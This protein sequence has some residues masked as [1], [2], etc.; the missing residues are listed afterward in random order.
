MD[1]TPLSPDRRAGLYVHV[2]FCT[3]ICPYCDFSVVGSRH[4]GRSDYVDVLLREAEGV[5]HGVPDESAGSRWNEEFGTVYFGGGTPSA[6]GR[7]EL[8]KLVRGLEQRVPIA[9]DAV[10]TLEA[11]PE[12]VDADFARLLNELGID[13]VSLGVQSLEASQLVEL[14]RGHRPADVERAVRL[15]RDA[16]VLW[17]SIDLIYA[18]DSDLAAWSRQLDRATELEPD[19]LS[20]YEL[21]LHD[22]TRFGRE[23][24]SG[25]RQVADEDVRLEMF[26]NTLRVL[27]EAGYSGYE[28]SNFSRG[29]TQRSPHNQKYW[30]GVHYL[31]LGPSAHSLRDNRRWWNRRTLR[32]WRDAV[33]AKGRAVEEEEVLGRGEVLLERLMAGTRTA[34]GIDLQ[35]IRH[36]LGIDLMELSEA[37][38]E[39]L[40]RAG[41]L[42]WLGADRLVPTV[43]GLAT[44]DRL[45]VD[46][47][48]GSLA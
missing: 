8:T 45:A 26:V 16:G 14:G 39:R 32:D 7:E 17:L 47:F 29:E 25:L 37:S 41:R 33:H 10:W 31:G 11:N 35:E 6:L 38:M 36:D 15:F 48:P 40:E 19:H 34:A 42:E 2:P 27:S 21:T 30:S 22:G 20:C 3:R 23:A 1:R 24:A 9:G 5:V 28:V 13:H 12:H 4:P 44:A 46:L 18:V 43:E